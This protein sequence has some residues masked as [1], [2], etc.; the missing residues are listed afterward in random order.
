[1]PSDDHNIL[2]IVTTN[3]TA[4]DDKIPPL[5]TTSP[6]QS[7]SPTKAGGLLSPHSPSAGPPSS[8]DSPAIIITDDGVIPPFLTLSRRSSVH[9][10]SSLALR[11]NNPQLRSP[12]S[13]ATTIS[14]TTE[15][16]HTAQQDEDLHHVKSNATSV[17]TCVGS[18]SASRAKR[19]TADSDTATAISVR[20][21]RKK[22]ASTEDTNLTPFRFRS[23]DLAMMLDPKNLDTL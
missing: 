8:L 22:G 23:N 9:F 1:M 6:V 7:L 21:R 13:F 3:L 4:D 19:D 5:L 14:D 16:D 11:D 18:Q 17:T 12:S 10:T 15:A 2:A 20:P